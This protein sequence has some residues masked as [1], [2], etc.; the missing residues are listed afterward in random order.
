MFSI[1]PASGWEEPQ[2]HPVQMTPQVQRD[3]HRYAYP[4]EDE[5]RFSRPTGY[6][7]CK[8]CDRGTLMAKTVFRMSVPV[9]LIGF[10]FLIPCVL[11]MI[12]FGILALVSLGAGTGGSLSALTKRVDVPVQS[13]VEATFRGNCA[14]SFRASY[15]RA[16]GLYPTMALTE[17]FCECGLSVYRETGSEAL[18]SHTCLGR[19]QE[20]GLPSVDRN[21]DA[22]YTERNSRVR[23]AASKSL[24]GIVGAGL[25]IVG[26]GFFIVCLISCFVGGLLGWLLVMRRRVLQ[27]SFCRA[28]VNAS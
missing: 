10:I 4:V 15:Q 7:Q 25:G 9:V 18:A 23:S 3:P 21:V 28:V 1:K 13:Q 5:P 14:K 26:S 11:G 24:L 27:C 2:R 22:F 8:V 17:Q 6:M 20:G 19:L 16:S 12:V